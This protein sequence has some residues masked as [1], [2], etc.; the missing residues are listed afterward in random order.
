[1]TSECLYVLS[2]PS[3]RGLK[4]G[5]TS[6]G[7]S[8]VKARM[9]ELRTTGV[10]ENFF[11]EYAILVEN[12]DSLEGEIHSFLREYRTSTNREFFNIDPLVVKLLLEV[13]VKG[14][15]TDVTKEV[16]SESSVVLPSE[17]LE[18]TPQEKVITDLPCLDFPY[19]SNPFA[20]YTTSELLIRYGISKQAFYDRLNSI[21]M[22]KT[23]IDTRGRSL[24]SACQVTVLDRVSRLLRQGYT[25][26]QIPEALSKND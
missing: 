26:H 7:V 3:I 2:N 21:K 10:P 5:R 6:N 20:L 13:R 1:M 16:R 23:S 24:Y 15:S 4:I 22:T 8:G 18:Q 14:N 11:C 9:K 17:K 25:L 19:P 12:S